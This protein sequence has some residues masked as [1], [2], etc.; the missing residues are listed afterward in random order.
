MYVIV[1][2]LLMTILLNKKSNETEV[3]LLKK[4]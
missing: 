3:N 2:A 1:M 4:K